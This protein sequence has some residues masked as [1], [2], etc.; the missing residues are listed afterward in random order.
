ME[1]STELIVRESTGRDREADGDPADPVGAGLATQAWRDPLRPAAERVADLLARMTLAE[2]VRP[3]LR[4]LGRR[5]TP[6]AARSPRHAENLAEQLALDELIRHGLGQLTRPFGTAP[7]DAAPARSSLARPQARSRR[8]SRFGIPAV[9]HE[10][11]LT[12]FAAWRAT[13]YPVPL[14][15][16]ASLRPRA[17]R[18]DGRADRRDHARGRR[19]PGPGARSST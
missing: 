19:P 5:P 13:V 12:G 15:W 18:R 11:C 3:A 6:G 2:K 10:E 17:G 8:P 9:A 14:A 1:L 7:V 16:G 4:R